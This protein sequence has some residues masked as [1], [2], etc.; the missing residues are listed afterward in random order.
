MG[1]KVSR[2]RKRQS[3]SPSKKMDAKKVIPSSPVNSTASEK[4]HTVSSSSYWLAKDN[5][6]QD[7]LMGQ[8]F[9]VKEGFGGNVL[10]KVLEVVRFDAGTKCL[11]VG[12]GPGTWCLDM[13]TEYPECQIYGVDMSDIFPE[14][15]RPPNTHFMQAN[16]LEGLPFEDNTFDFVQARLLVAA[17]KVEQWPLVIKEYLRVLKPGGILQMLEPDYKETGGGAS[18]K[19]VQTVIKLCHMRGQNPHIGAD[20]A[21]LM[22]EAGLTILE[23]R[24][25][26]IDHSEDTKLAAEWIWDWCYFAKVTCEVIGPVV[27]VSQEDYPQFLKDIESSMKE[28]HFTTHGYCVVGQKSS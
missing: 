28:Y 14:A 6:E 2:Q 1:S 25:S 8:H 12:C 27:G 19:L 20:L 5:E 22:E 15:I 17:L 3:N 4:Y 13:A 23:N 10:P 16:V 24:Y 9:A 7:R 18:L 21:R 11:D 26:T